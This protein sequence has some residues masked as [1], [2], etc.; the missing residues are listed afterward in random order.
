MK[1]KEGGASPLI[2]TAENCISQPP[3]QIAQTCFVHTQEGVW[4][5]IMASLA[6]DNPALYQN[7]QL[8]NWVYM[9]MGDQTQQNGASLYTTSDPWTNQPVNSNVNTVSSM[10]KYQRQ[11]DPWSTS[12]VNTINAVAPVSFLLINNVGKYQMCVLIGASYVYV[13]EH[14]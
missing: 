3:M 5:G 13:K 11:P 2:G 8:L 6:L 4:F 1:Y 9:T 12:A 7:A 14:N 10:F